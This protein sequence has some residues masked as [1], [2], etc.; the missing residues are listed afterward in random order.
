MDETNQ[1]SKLRTEHQNQTG[2]ER[3]EEEPDFFGLN[4]KINL[5]MAG[6]CGMALDAKKT[7]CKKHVHSHKTHKDKVVGA[8]RGS[9]ISGHPI[10]A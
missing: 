7:A 10:R 4:D 9:T 1:R 5:Q 6:P 2:N 8:D 3:N